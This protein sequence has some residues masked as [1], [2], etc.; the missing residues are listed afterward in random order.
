MEPLYETLSTRITHNL[1]EFD[2]YE[3]NRLPNSLLFAV[4]EI[5]E[6][7]KFFRDFVFSSTSPLDF[8]AS[9]VYFP[10]KVVPYKK[11][12]GVAL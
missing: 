12:V 9:Y 4:M 7:G 2:C 6:I 10:Y 1:Y 8:L 3:W 11:C 5:F